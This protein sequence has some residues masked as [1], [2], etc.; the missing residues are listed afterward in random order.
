MIEIN[1]G[2]IGNAKV[3]IFFTII[4][5]G[6]FYKTFLWGLVN[7]FLNAINIWKISVFHTGLESNSEYF[8]IV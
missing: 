7:Y 8:V 5:M 6:E 2:W 4:K 1:Q 3:F